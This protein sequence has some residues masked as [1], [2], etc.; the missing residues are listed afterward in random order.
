[1][2]RMRYILLVA[3]VTL[4]AVACERRPIEESYLKVYL[5]LNIERNITNYELED[6]AP[7][8]MRVMFFDSATKEFISHDYVSHEGGYIF[9]PYGDVDMV[10]YNLEAGEIH[11]RNYYSWM[12]IEAFTENINDFQRNQFARYI[13]SRV[14]TRPSY[15]DIR[16]TPGHLFVARRE[17]IHIPHHITNEAF[18]ISATARSVVESWT[19][20]IN[21]V[22]GT[23]WLGGVTMM[24]SGQ[25]GSYFI[26]RGE[27]ST[28]SVALYFDTDSKQRS[29]VSIYSRF[30][31][32]GRE[33]TSG[34]AVL[35]SVLFTDT[36]GHS[37][38]HN[39][40]V[41]SQMENNPEQHIVINADIDIPKPEAGG[42]FEP[43]VDNWREFEY[44]IDI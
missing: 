11:V 36:Q 14:D 31:T 27:P 12:D 26:A 15:D 35:L 38:L 32:F 44:D 28:N 1:M 17:G 30:E 19:I 10:V 6:D 4:V 37:Y 41:S 29:A 13:N 3:I 20:E 5:D 8:L 42:G 23:E 24:I 34:D 25:S 22:K 43:S 33:Q 7:G 21:G 39:F 16:T 2:S 9:A 18:I 40:D